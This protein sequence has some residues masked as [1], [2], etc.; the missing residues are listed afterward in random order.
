MFLFIVISSIYFYYSHNATKDYGLVMWA[1]GA[2]TMFSGLV[3]AA[4]FDLWWGERSKVISPAETKEGDTE[5]E[6]ETS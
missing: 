1:S 5:N 6:K 4:G 2:A 3:T